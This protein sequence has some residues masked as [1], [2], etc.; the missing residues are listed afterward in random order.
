MD[1]TVLVYIERN[2][3]YL[4]LFR[5]KKENDLNE[6]KWMGVG[7]HIE[8][9]ET[10]EEALV[11]EVKEETGLDVLSYTYCGELLFINDD[12]EE[13]IYLYKVNDFKGD[14]IECNEGDLKWVDIDKV[15][16]LKMWEGDYIF[17]PKIINFVKE[18]NMTLIYKGKELVKVL[19]KEAESL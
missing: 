14:L 13:I 6:G 9:G 17:V 15:L 18:I 19:D 11:R 16:S 8:P 4:M 1:K 2:N 3:Q 12:Y 5:N 10:K 7:G